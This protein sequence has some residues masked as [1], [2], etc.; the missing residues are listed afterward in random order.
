[1]HPSDAVRTVHHFYGVPA[2]NAVS[3]HM[4]KPLDELQLRNILQNKKVK[5]I[6]D[7]NTEELFQTEE[8]KETLY[9]N[10]MCDPELDLRPKRK[11][12]NCWDN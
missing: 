12:R 4:S 6:K 8:T 2:N 5:V 7:R 3:L 10:V 9:L 11:E 1:M